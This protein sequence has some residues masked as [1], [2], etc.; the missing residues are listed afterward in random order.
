MTI[1][2]IIITQ[3]YDMI[4]SQDGLAVHATNK[5]GHY[6]PYLTKQRF[7]VENYGRLFERL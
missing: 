4:T 3:R 5:M 6:D 7:S 2:C 1:R